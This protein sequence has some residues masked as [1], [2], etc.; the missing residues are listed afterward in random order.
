LI[1]TRLRLIK[2]SKYGDVSNLPAIT[3]TTS[4]YGGAVGSLLEA[5]VFQWK[6]NLG[7]NVQV[8]QLEPERF[9]YNIRNEIDEIFDIG[10]WIADYAH[11]QD[12]IDV[13]FNSNAENNYGSYSNPQVDDIIE[14]A[15]REVDK[16]KSFAFYRRTDNCQ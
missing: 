5:I 15:N 10:G 16:S 7:V 8:R 1:S 14:Q 11:P 4:G 13:L 6:Q 3:L 12:F 9:Y 2:A